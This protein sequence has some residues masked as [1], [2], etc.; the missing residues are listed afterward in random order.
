MSFYTPSARANDN[1]PCA[2]MVR[3]LNLFAG[4]LYLKSLPEYEELCRFL[5]IATSSFYFKDG[6]VSAEGFVDPRTRKDV[7]WPRQCP[8]GQSSLPFLK[9]VFLLRTHG[10]DYFHTHMGSLDAG[11]AVHESTFHKAT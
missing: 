11:R 2:E 9:Q 8:F 1:L 10:Q 6:Q 3:I 5:G 7:G 4:T